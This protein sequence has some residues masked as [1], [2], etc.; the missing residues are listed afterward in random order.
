MTPV[1]QTGGFTIRRAQIEDAPALAALARQTFID[2]YA[3]LCHPD[4]VQM[5]CDQAFGVA[6]QSQ[7]ILNPHYVVLLQF[8]EQ[9]LI[10]FAQVAHKE[11][12]ACVTQAKVIALY[13]YYLKQSWHGKGAALPLL[14]AAEQVA[15]QQGADYLW[16][17]MWKHNQRAA[18]FYRK[19]GFQWVGETTYQFGP[20]L[21]VDDVFLKNMK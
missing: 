10:G 12:P 1:S 15:K 4:D 14:T 19:V 20:N 3:A 21:E 9:E 5:H 13:R 2:T 8:H 16:L 7:E 18:A 17:G 6:Q 11:V